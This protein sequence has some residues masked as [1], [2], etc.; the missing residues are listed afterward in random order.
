MNI[1][2]VFEHG[3]QL[4]LMPGSR[5]ERI[6][7]GRINLERINLMAT[8][9]QDDDGE[10]DG[11]DEDGD[12]DHMSNFFSFQ[13]RRGERAAVKKS[14]PPAKQRMHHLL[15]LSAISITSE[16]LL[17]ETDDA[18]HVKPNDQRPTTS[19]KSKFEISSNS[20][21]TVC[22]DDENPASNPHTAIVSRFQRY[23]CTHKSLSLHTKASLILLLPGPLENISPVDISPGLGFLLSPSSCHRW[24]QRNQ[25]NQQ[26]LDKF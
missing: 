24:F 26:G 21:I 19:S 2:P 5:L 20:L 4:G 3:N 9:C 8:N 11:D 18:V 22:Q 10:I 14:S 13:R 25:K 6:N 23:Q 12:D 16:L 17:C 15:F 7:L 1:E